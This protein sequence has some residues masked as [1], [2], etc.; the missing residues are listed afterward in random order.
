MNPLKIKEVPVDLGNNHPT[1]KFG[2]VLPKHEFTCGIIAPKGKTFTNHSKRENHFAYKSSQV[3][4]GL[5]SQYYYLF[6]DRGQW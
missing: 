5:L 1:P 3:V 6:P 4:Q 2:D